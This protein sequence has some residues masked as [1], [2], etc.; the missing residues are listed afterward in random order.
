MCTKIVPKRTLYR[1]ADGLRGMVFDLLPFF[2][3]FWA[4]SLFTSRPVDL[5]ALSIYTC[6]RA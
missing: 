2:A 3:R 4:S 6:R 5:I 1:I